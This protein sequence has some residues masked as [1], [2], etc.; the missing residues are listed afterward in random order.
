[1]LGYNGENVASSATLVQMAATDNSLTAKIAPASFGQERLWFLQRMEPESSTYNSAVAVRLSGELNCVLLE[2]GIKAWIERHESLRT[3]FRY[4]DAQLL[5]VIAPALSLSL[6]RPAGDLPLREALTVESMRPFDLEQGPLIRAAL[7]DSGPAEH[8]LMVTIHHLV[9]DGWSIQLLLG[10]LAA[11]YSAGVKGGD[12][13]LPAVPMQYADFAAWQREYVRTLDSHTEY[14]RKQL[15]GNPP[16]LDVPSD[17]PR[18]P[19]RLGRGALRTALFPLA[20]TE[21]LKGVARRR[22]A[23]LFMTLLA[24]FQ[25]LLFRY[26]GQEDIS[27]GTPVAGRT[28]TQVE[29]LVGC[30]INTLVLRTDLTGNPAFEEV[31]DRVRRTTLD[32]LSHQDVPFERLVEILR[33]ERDM[34]RS[35]FFQIMFQ[36]RN[37]PKAE[38]EM[39]GLIIT[40]VPVESEWAKFDL[41]L[42]LTETPDGLLCE[43]SY[44]TDL[45]DGATVDR[46]LGCYRV[47]LESAA[48]TPECPISRLDILSAEDRRLLVQWNHT[49][50]AYPKAC[51]HELFEK[52]VERTPDAVAIVDDE[53]R[54]LSYRE[55]N[56]RANQ[57]AHYLRKAGVGR[58]VLVSVVMERCLEL[59]IALCA[60]LKAGGAFVSIDPDYPAERVRFMLEDT[61]APVL[62]T[63]ARLAERLPR[64]SGIVLCIDADWD[65]VSREDTANPVEGARPQDLAYMMYTSGSTGKPKGA[66]NVH[67]GICN[68]ILWMCDQLGL[69]PSEGVLNKTPLSFDVAIWEIFFLS[70]WGRGS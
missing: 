55:L 36:L 65:R 61:G 23:S 69:L 44:D 60:V 21:A 53:D 22:R 8:V 45:F 49:E 54:R 46:M 18:G 25:T 50:R 42:D 1:M 12:P 14:W 24:G 48:A 70:L 4:Q 38:L 33:P 27:V 37:M 62:L 29:R 47:L 34:T 31:L 63:Q 11:V 51:L 7:F 41:S 39:P 2:R 56:S 40:P 19:V 16:S 3:T 20:L 13:A 15:A 35:P 66:L 17:R 26:T 28:R 58:D 10:E 68:R 5:Q 67:R 30:L 64:S 6:R 32:A 9:I 59:P 57:L 43:M 52:Q